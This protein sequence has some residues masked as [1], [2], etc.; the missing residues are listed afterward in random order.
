MK[1]VIYKKPESEKP[2]TDEKCPVCGGEMRYDIIPCPDGKEG[3]LVLHYGY[4]CLK[5][6]KIY[7]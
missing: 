5:C 2:N 7:Q 4:I 3:C 1:E 6:R